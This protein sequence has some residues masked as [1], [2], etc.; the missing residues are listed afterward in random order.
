MTASSGASPTKAGSDLGYEARY[1]LRGRPGGIIALC[2][3]L[4]ALAALPGMSTWVRVTD[5]VFFGG[6]GLFLLAVAATRQVAL[7]L[8][9]EGIT[10]G[11]TPPR[12]R[13][14][15]RL[16]PWS[17]IDGVVLWRQHL[18]R[19]ASMRYVGIVRRPDAPPLAGQRAA[20]VG[21]VAASILTPGVPADVVMASR[22]VNGWRLDE[23]RLAAA[24]HHFAPGVTI[25]KHG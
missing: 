20:A 11:G 12:Y 19:G 5:L 1:G 13:S 14:G 10:L 6:G 16:V 7:R 18:P 21:R 3:A 9:A 22:A 2:L 25:S 8:D 23:T 24:V 4:A 17:E 15:T